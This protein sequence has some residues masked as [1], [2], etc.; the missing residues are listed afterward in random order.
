[1]LRVTIVLVII[2]NGLMG[3]SSTEQVEHKHKAPLNVPASLLLEGV[4][5]KTEVEK[6]TQIFALSP[7]QQ[8]QFLDY[9]YASENQDELSHHRLYNYLELTVDGFHYRGETY[10]AQV[11]H[12]RKEGNCLS[13]AI[14]TT[15]LA[16]L[17]GLEVEYQLVSSAPVYRRYEKLMFLSSHVRT[18]VYANNYVAPPN[19]LVIRKPSIVIDYFPEDG[20]ITGL[21][22]NHQDFVSMYYQNLAAN[23]VLMKR[24][25][26]AHSLLMAA[27][28][29]SPSN[30]ETLNTLAILYKQTGY[31]EAARE[32]LEFAYAN[33][34]A[35]AN[36]ISNFAQLLE[37]QGDSK[38]AA[39]LRDEIIHIDDH[40]PYRW[41]DLANEFYAKGNF[42]LAN[43]YFLRAVDVAPYLH[44]GHFGLAIT[45][46]KLGRKTRAQT[47]FESART[48]AKYTPKEGMYNAKWH[49]H[50]RFQNK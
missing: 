15:A 43:K 40:N 17:V 9:Y 7:I 6:P 47:A 49:L 44:E 32:L 35:S 39:L 33:T 20:D 12:A 11:A 16:R 38:R 48:L 23:A 26:H 14:L 29:V 13:L 8:K 46:A 4:F 36:L 45:F 24:F 18:I 30:A 2:L 50:Q 25:E 27:M 31:V 10:N 3:C 5:E 19:T 34:S 42:K 22:V 1:M 37:Q 28:N 21:S 41:L